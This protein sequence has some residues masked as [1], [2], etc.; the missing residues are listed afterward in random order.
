MSTGL[1]NQG[2]WQRNW[3]RLSR[4]NKNETVFQEPK[5][6]FLLEGLGD[7]PWSLVHRLLEVSK[8]T[9]RMMDSAK[10]QSSE[11]WTVRN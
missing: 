8:A 3:K 10:S 1:Q 2:Q 7:R 11:C 5:E 4:E 9:S 6:I